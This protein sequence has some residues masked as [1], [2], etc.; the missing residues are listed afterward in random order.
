MHRCTRTIRAAHRLMS[1]C[2]RQT[3]FN[4][5]SHQVKL[6]SI[7][8]WTLI[9]LLAS[10]ELVDAVSSN[11]TMSDCCCQQMRLDYVATGKYSR[12]TSNLV[13]SVG[14]NRTFAIVKFFQTGK[15]NTLS[16]SRNNQVSL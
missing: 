10:E 14:R 5:L 9:Q 12:L 2:Y 15:V 3:L 13:V 16:N 11:R 1:L 7:N 6:M 4:Q 8:F